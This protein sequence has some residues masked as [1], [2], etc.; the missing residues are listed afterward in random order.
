MTM[1]ISSLR[2]CNHLGMLYRKEVSVSGDNQDP[3]RLLD[4]SP[5]ATSPLVGLGYLPRY[6]ELRSKI[7]GTVSHLPP[8]LIYFH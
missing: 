8:S 5:E 7:L 3:N 6:R 4:N 1:R 2:P